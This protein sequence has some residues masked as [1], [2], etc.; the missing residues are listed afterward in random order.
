MDLLTLAEIARELK[1]PETT[2]RY[3]AKTYEAFLP[4]VQKRRR[5]LY[6]KEAIE[7]FRVIEEC[8][9]NGLNREQT[10]NELT[11][12]FPSIGEASEVGGVPATTKQ[13][14]NDETTVPAIMNQFAEMV[15]QQQEINRKL[16]EILD[17][18]ENRKGVWERLLDRIFGKGG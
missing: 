14:R 16:A 12:R 9:S 4:Y 7:A 1:I 8:S 17:R 15:N 5:K 18:L 3:R 2:L 6:R 10:T 11:K 13:Q